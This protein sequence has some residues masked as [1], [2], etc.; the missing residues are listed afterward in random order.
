MDRNISPSFLS[1][2]YTNNYTNKPLLKVFVHVP[3]WILPHAKQMA[4]GN[5]LC[6]VGSSTQCSVTAWWGGKGW[7]VGGRFK[8][9][10][11]CVYMWLIHSDVWQK[12]GQ[13]YK[14]IILH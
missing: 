4:S 6:D 12:P 14:T 9:E 5:M 8:R 7:D 11:T 2:C 10:G 1:A 13:Y 3:T